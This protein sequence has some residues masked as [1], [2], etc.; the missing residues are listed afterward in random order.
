MRKVTRLHP[1][2]SNLA[3][4]SSGSTFT[5]NQK[6]LKN[7]KTK[8]KLKI[9]ILKGKKV[10]Q[11]P[12]VSRW[13]WMATLY[14]EYTYLFCV[15]LQSMKEACTLQCQIPLVHG[16]WDSALIAYV[17]VKRLSDIPICSL[18]YILILSNLKRLNV[19]CFS[20]EAN[21]RPVEFFSM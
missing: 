13:K 2:G 20:L 7:I 18:T 5:L 1:C 21:H 10:M 4:I 11:D 19:S 9:D 8:Y 15:M 16:H 3:Y 6:Y 14:R 12:V 17:P